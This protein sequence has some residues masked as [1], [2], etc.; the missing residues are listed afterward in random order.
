MK[1]HFIG[2]GGIGVSALAQ[3]Y[4]SKGHNI[5]GSD[6]TESE[7]TLALKKI[8]AKIR[9]GPHR[10]ENIPLKA[11]LIIHSPA[12]GRE[13]PELAQAHNVVSSVPA[14]IRWECAC[15]DILKPWES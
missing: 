13:N 3:Y 5:S 15:L 1:I 10:A 9:I 11:D 2:I 12:V 8:G 7:T 6:L 14:A 4:I